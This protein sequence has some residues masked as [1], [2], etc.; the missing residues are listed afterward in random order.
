MAAREHVRLQKG[1]PMS[2]P[3]VPPPSTNVP[4]DPA[5]FVSR[6]IQVL[7]APAE[8]FKS[9]RKTGGFVEP[10]VAAVIYGL[11]SGVLSAV[12]AVT[13]MTAIGGAGGGLFGSIAGIGMVIFM[14]IMAVIGLFIGAVIF[15][16]ISSIGGGSTDFEACV[17]VA[18]SCMAILPVHS[19]FGFLNGI[20]FYLGLLVSLLVSLYGLWIAYNGLVHGL[21][22]KDGVAKIVTGI[23]ALL[24]ILMTIMG[25]MA[26]AVLGRAGAMLEGAAEENRDAVAAWQKTAEELQR[27]AQKAQEEMAKSGTTGDQTTD[28]TEA[29]AEPEPEPESEKSE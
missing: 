6:T 13:H 1:E 9:L 18:A 28:A 4:F 23:F 26:G 17:R 3:S 29:P 21:G 7:T 10:I 11:I 2:M 12:W 14:P 27:A 20:S 25:L 15:L 19:L 22:C 5:A 24:A 16:V 8:H